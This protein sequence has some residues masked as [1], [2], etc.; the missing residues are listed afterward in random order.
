M[1]AYITINVST[2]PDFDPDGENDIDVIRDEIVATLDEI[3]V[4][5]FIVDIGETA[6]W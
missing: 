3:G 2:R 5:A 6:P 1:K 4:D